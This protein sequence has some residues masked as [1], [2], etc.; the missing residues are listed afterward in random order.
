M[1]TTCTS[2]VGAEHLDVMW[3]RLSIDSPSSS[4]S[5]CYFSLSFFTTTA[6]NLKAE[7]WGR[8]VLHNVIV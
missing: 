2:T 4:S 5:S 1:S 7:A 6:R 3:I 8:G